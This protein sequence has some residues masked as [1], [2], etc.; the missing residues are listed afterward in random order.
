MGLYYLFSAANWTV[1]CSFYVVYYSLY[2][3]PRYMN[4]FIIWNTFLLKNKKFTFL[5][6]TF[7]FIVTMIYS[8]LIVSVFITDLAVLQISVNSLEALL[9]KSSEAYV[10]IRIDV[11]FS[12]NCIPDMLNNMADKTSVVWLERNSLNNSSW[13]LLYCKFYL[14]SLLSS[15]LCFPVWIYF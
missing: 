12:Y 15:S 4:S 11:L 7:S 13:L 2:I 5:C 6:S 3:G 8:Y 1:R 10:S 9:T 14:V